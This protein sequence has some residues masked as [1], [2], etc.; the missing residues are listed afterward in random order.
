MARP[1][2]YTDIENE[3][4]NKC[5]HKKVQDFFKKHI[6]GKD[7]D[8]CL[9]YLDMVSNWIEFG[10]ENKYERWENETKWKGIL[11]Y[12]LKVFPNENLRL[13][14]PDTK[15]RNPDDKRYKKKKIKIDDPI[16]R[17]YDTTATTDYE[18]EEPPSDDEGY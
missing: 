17:D 9:K 16:D 2:K 12:I 15:F 18:N 3:I 4:L 13:W 1:K 10:Y 7:F 5:K 14:Y 8:T 6:F 11:R